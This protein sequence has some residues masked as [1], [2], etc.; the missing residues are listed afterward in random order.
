MHISMC[1]RI[2]FY[3]CF[4]SQQSTVSMDSHVKP[5]AYSAIDSTPSAPAYNVQDQSHQ[6]THESAPL[7]NPG[8]VYGSGNVTYAVSPA[9]VIVAYQSPYDTT[10][11]FV[12]SCFV[13]WLCNLPT[14]LIA[15]ILAGEQF[16]WQLVHLNG[17]HLILNLKLIIPSR[18]HCQFGLVWLLNGPSTQEVIRANTRCGCSLT[19]YPGR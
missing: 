15:F 13:L 6:F 19:S 5:P 2:S 17:C 3:F 14:G 12:L 8:P 9:P 1:F 4:P 11:I 7:L 16:N 18:L 10:G